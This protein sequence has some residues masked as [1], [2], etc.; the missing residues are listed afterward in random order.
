MH[1]NLDWQQTGF[2]AQKYYYK[3]RSP[4]VRVFFQSDLPQTKSEADL[5]ASDLDRGLNPSQVFICVT[6]FSDTQ[7]EV[8]ASY[9]HGRYFHLQYD[10]DVVVLANRGG[11]EQTLREFFEYLRVRLEPSP[12][13]HIVQRVLFEL[14]LRDK[15]WA[16]AKLYLKELEGMNQDGGLKSVIAENQKRLSASEHQIYHR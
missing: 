6:R 10:G 1:R 8:L 4:A 14:A 15:R 12:A 13:H 16:D 7:P 11:L 3:D 9:P 2:I 5:I